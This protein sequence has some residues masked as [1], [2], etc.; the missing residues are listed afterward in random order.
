M[1]GG[2][3]DDRRVLVKDGSG[4]THVMFSPNGR[5][6][7]ADLGGDRVVIIDVVDGA[8]TTVYRVSPGTKAPPQAAGWS[9]DGR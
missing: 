7:E 3:N 5:S 9:P 4:A 1:V 6:L 2:P 8:S